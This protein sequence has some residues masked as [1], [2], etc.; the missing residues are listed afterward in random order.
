MITFNFYTPK[1]KLPNN[2]DVIIFLIKEVSF[3]IE[4]FD[5][6]LGTVEYE[7]AEF[8]ETGVD[9]GTSI[10]YEGNEHLINDPNVELRI[11]IDADD[12][13]YYFEDDVF[14]WNYPFDNI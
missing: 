8:D 12:A 3:D 9:T 7:F 5:V 4:Y 6:R 14:C 11:L 10:C 13:T 1:E 2:G